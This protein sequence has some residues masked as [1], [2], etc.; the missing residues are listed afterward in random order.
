GL[1]M[2]FALTRSLASLLFGVS[3]RNPVVFTGATLIAVAA[4]LI[5][6]YVPARRAA[7]VDPMASLRYE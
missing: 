4:G 6:S 1:P 2:A 5:A 7:R 3:P